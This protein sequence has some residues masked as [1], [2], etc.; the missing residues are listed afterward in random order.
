MSLIEKGI[1]KKH[2][3]FKRTLQQI[4]RYFESKSKQKT[5]THCDIFRQWGLKND[6]IYDKPIAKKTINDKKSR[7]RPWRK[8]SS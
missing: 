3:H 8:N 2:Y 5:Q 4:S 1:S 7:R 6:E